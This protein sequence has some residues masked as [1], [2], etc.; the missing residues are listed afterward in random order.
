M[1]NMTQ[2]SRRMRRVL[3]YQY[4]LYQHRSSHRP[5]RDPGLQPERTVMSWGRTMMALA[6][7]SCLYLRWWPYHGAWVLI[8]LGTAMLTAGA[9]YA[10]QRVRYQKQGLGIAVERVHADVWAVVALTGL[11]VA[12]A[13]SVLAIMVFTLLYA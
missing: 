3:A 8:P 11:I 10:T 1:T 2:R 12:M 13:L 9:I 7:V 4:R 6:V 5:H